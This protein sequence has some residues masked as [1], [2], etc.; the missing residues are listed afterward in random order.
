V[1]SREELLTVPRQWI[2]CCG[3]P[4][5]SRAHDS[6]YT[7]V[8][9]EWDRKKAEANLVK[10]GVSFDEAT[11]AFADPAALD[12][13]DLGH[14]EDEARFLRLGRSIFDRVLVVAYTHRKRSYGEAIR[15][16][17][18]RRASRKERAA[19]GRAVED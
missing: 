1:Q 3:K 17:S 19:Y 7:K 5:T 10:H 9:F 13:P 2:G 8:V 4:C 15:I 16:I 11:T 14:S 12:G 6:V 18:A